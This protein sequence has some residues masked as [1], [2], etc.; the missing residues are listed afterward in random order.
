[1]AISRQIAGPFSDAITARCGAKKPAADEC[2]DCSLV[3]PASLISDV[4]Y[5]NVAV[6]YTRH[7]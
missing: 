4:P 2:T 7:L 6:R 1:M 5:L 3:A